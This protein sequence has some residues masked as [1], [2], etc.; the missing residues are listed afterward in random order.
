MVVARL[1]EATTPARVRVCLCVCCPLAA[2]GPR[3][4]DGH[5]GKAIREGNMGKFYRAPDPHV[6]PGLLLPQNGR[7]GCTKG[8]KR[9]RKS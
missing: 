1:C 4:E 8:G 2:Y 3:L 9:M 7:A 5:C 6:G